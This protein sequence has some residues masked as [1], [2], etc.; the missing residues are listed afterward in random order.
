MSTPEQ[1][2]AIRAAEWAA[3]RD[4]ARAAIARWRAEVA[5]ARTQLAILPDPL[6]WAD[7]RR[8]PLTANLGHL[9]WAA[10]IAITPWLRTDRDL[11]TLKRLTRQAV[12]RVQR[13]WV[14]TLQDGL[15]SPF[16]AHSATSDRQAAV[17]EV[18]GEPIATGSFVSDLDSLDGILRDLHETVGDPA[19][20]D[21]FGKLMPQDEDGLDDG[22]EV[23]KG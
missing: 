20:L 17:A 10:P 13:G 15:L 23:E 1:M 9:W 3:H 11:A 16:I 18:L 22:D 14:S 12:R 8:E 6:P 19:Y 21:P 7:P 5:W 2:A 4:Y